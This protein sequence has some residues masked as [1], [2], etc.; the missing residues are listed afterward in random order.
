MK[1]GIANLS[2]L[3]ITIALVVISFVIIYISACGIYIFEKDIQPGVFGSML[4]TIT[5]TLLIY[6][7]IGY[8]NTAPITIGGTIISSLV[9]IVGFIVGIL[10]LG[11][12]FIGIIRTCSIIRRETKKLFG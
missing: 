11:T 8:A 1:T 4:N 10:L 2:F 7:T 3:R 6:A 12:V 9:T 5:Y